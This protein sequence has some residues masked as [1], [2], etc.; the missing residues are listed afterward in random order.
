[1][2]TKKPLKR[3]VNWVNFDKCWFEN[4]KEPTSRPKKSSSGKSAG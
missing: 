1:M 4:T 3:P 2:S